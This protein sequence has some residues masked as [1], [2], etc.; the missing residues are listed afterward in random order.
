MAADTTATTS[1]AAAPSAANRAAGPVVD[2]TGA[3]K[4]PPVAMPA[5]SPATTE[6]ELGASG[7]IVTSTGGGRGASGRAGSGSV[8]IG[9]FGR[10]ARG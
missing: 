9:G 1:S 3:P 5:D 6:S 7:R 10:F 2:S 8:G 4:R